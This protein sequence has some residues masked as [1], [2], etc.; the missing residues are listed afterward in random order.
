M[1]SLET[2]EPEKL[3]PFNNLF[4]ARGFYTGRNDWWIYI[5]GIFLAIIGYVV[6][7]I[8]II[9]PLMGVATN[10]GLSLSE[11]TKNPNILF[12]PEAMGMNRSVM[13]A[14]LMLMFVFCLLGLF[15]A[16]R[17]IHRK[18]ISSVISGF[19]KI[20]WSRYFFSFTVWSLLLIILTVIS[21]YSAPEELEI[22][23]Q[24][25][26]FLIL[27][28]VACIFIPIQTATEEILFRGYLMQGLGIG[29][30][31]GLMPLITTSVLFG[32]M[33]GANPE[34]EAFGFAT[35]MPYYMSFGLFLGL[36]TLLDEGLELA[37]GIHCA[38]NLI[39]SLLVTSKNSV[40]QTDAVFYQKTED[41]GGEIY[42]WLVMAAICFGILY[43]K[44]RWKNWNVIIK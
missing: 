21:Y 14:L 19:E 37:M 6:A 15:V 43:V 18:T 40:L 2:S 3:N 32:L 31:N 34:T 41:P 28:L 10:H 9:V 17:F 27:L 16:I 13:L 8:I 25:K 5:L 36:I 38:N 11:I 22:R 24:L 29:S 4:L 33:H 12:N 26:P 20:R 35:M 7:Q 39:S 1:E 44:Y 30:K 42:A 23:F